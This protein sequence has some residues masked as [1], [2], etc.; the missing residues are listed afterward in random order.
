MATY[1]FDNIDIDIKQKAVTKLIQCASQH[2]GY[3]FGGYVRNVLVPQ[4]LGITR[5]TP[6]WKDVD[7]WFKT[8][9]N[10]QSF[11][12]DMGG[13]LRPAHTQKHRDDDSQ[14][15]LYSF[16]RFQY[17]LYDG[18]KAVSFV[19]II[20]SKTYPVNDFNVNRIMCQIDTEFMYGFNRI[21]F[22]KHSLSSM[23][24]KQRSFQKVVGL[25]SYIKVADCT[26]FQEIANKVAT[27]TPF[28]F[29]NRINSSSDFVG[30]NYSSDVQPE[31]MTY[32]HRLRVISRYLLEGWNIKLPNG[33]II[34]PSD[35]K[36]VTNSPF[37]SYET[38]T[39]LN[40]LF[41]DDIP[42][43]SS[44]AASSNS[45]TSINSSTSSNELHPPTSDAC[46]TGPTPTIPATAPTIPATVPTTQK[47]LSSILE[48]IDSRLERLCE[49]LEHKL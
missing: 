15:S 28:Y 24:K 38:K 18:E 29:K 17:Y 13:A 46:S 34:K 22:T 1:Y 20:E 9:D 21:K 41:R 31:M 33:N 10:I 2:D 19:D 3:A 30:G 42:S 49:V 40:N 27:M 45:S 37:H 11:L 39:L 4:A 23:V 43:A 44:S 7:L 5:A 47:S 26:L 16:K 35:I 14:Q 8:S 25:N 12:N 6:Q 48:S 36:S 32:A